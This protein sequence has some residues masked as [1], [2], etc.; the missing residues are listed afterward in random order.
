M[1]VVW[2]RGAKVNGKALERRI[3]LA[4]SAWPVRLS[5][6]GFSASDPITGAESPAYWCS[7]MPSLGGVRHLSGLSHSRDLPVRF[8]IPSGLYGGD[9]RVLYSALSQGSKLVVC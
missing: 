6:L 3:A 5:P 1:S 7:S 2:P 8:C 9:L 4:V